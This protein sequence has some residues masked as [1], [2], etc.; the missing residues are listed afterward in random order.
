MMEQGLESPEESYSQLRAVSGK[1]E[2]SVFRHSKPPKVSRPIPFLGK[3][4]EMLLYQ[5]KG[6]NWGRGRHGVQYKWDRG[7]WVSWMMERTG[8]KSWLCIRPWGHRSGEEK[9]QRPWERNRQG[10]ET[11]ESAWPHGRENYRGRV[12]TNGKIWQLT[13]GKN[14]KVV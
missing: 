7:E 4:L 14:Q 6:V 8:P 11:D 1:C 9:T 10:I 5:N 3:L 12:W 2:Y 13:P